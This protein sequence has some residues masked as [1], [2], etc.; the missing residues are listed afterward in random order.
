MPGI[1]YRTLPLPV[2]IV[3]SV[4]FSLLAGE[5]TAEILGKKGTR[6]DIA[7]YDR[8]EAGIIRTWVRPVGFPDKIQPLLQ[9]VNLG[10]YAIVSVDTLDRFAGEQILALDSVGIT[11]GILSHSA[12]VDHDSL[13]RAVKGT[14]L[15]GYRYVEPQDIRR[16]ASEFAQSGNSGDTGIVVDHSFDVKGAGTIILGKVVSGTVSKYDELTLYPS[17]IKVMVK[18]IQMHDDPVDAASSPARVGLAIKGAKPEDVGRGDMLCGY[19]CPVTSVL[20]LDFEKTPYYSGEPAPG[21]MCLVS[22]GLQ[23]VAGKFT[24][25]DPVSI[26][27]DRQVARSAQRCTVLKPESRIRIMGSGTIR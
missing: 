8:K 22:L 10:E 5:D 4:N 20:N 3:Q 26:R 21:Q 11:E 25:T 19:K 27:L 1:V 14:V 24:S 2:T 12:M 9:A 6:T 15:E 23:V 17:G 18:S 7:L 16:A 13:M